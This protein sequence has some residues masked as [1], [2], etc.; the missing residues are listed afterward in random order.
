M[1]KGK[2]LKELRKQNVEVGKTMRAMALTMQDELESIGSETRARLITGFDGT[3]TAI[4][5]LAHGITIQKFVPDKNGDVNE[6]IY[7]LPPYWPALKWLADWNR[8]IINEGPKTIQ[9][10]TIDPEA[11]Q[12]LKDFVQGDKDRPAPVAVEGVFQLG[13]NGD[14]DQPNTDD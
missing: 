12:L 7:S 3:L 1:P 5:R 14:H 13:R 11:K 8:Q 2:H 4:E 10:H 6:V 9:E